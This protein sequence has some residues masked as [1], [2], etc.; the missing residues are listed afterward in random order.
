MTGHIPVDLQTSPGP[1]AASGDALG[2]SAG[3]SE[4][5]PRKRGNMTSVRPARCVTG[6]R[7]REDTAPNKVVTPIERDGRRPR[8]RAL[9]CAGQPGLR[10]RRGQW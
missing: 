7:Q 5:R 6:R 10:R 3:G 1:P 4:H 2:A 8:E 9:A